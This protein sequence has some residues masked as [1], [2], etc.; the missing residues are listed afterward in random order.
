MPF[1]KKSPAVQD[2]SYR[3]L[4]RLLIAV[5][6]SAAGTATVVSAAA[7][8]TTSTAAAKAAAFLEA[9]TASTAAEASFLEATATV[10]A[11]A[12]F[13]RTGFIYDQVSA[14]DFATV[15]LSDRS[16]CLIIVWHFNKAKTFASLREFVH[17]NFSG[18]YFT[19]WC[20]QVGQI[21]V[22]Q[23]PTQVSYVNVHFE[24]SLK[25]QK[26]VYSCPK[27][28]NINA[29]FKRPEKLKEHNT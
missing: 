4:I 10:S 29:T 20:K 6:E 23:A 7:A 27:T 21:L 17:Y 1:P 22:F 28:M 5:S 16:L 8:A 3:R 18:S 19:E 13:F 26:S 9:A 12:A 2:F 24:K 25:K 15:Q 11:A 14:F